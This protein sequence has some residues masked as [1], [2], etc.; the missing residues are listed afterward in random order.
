MG[1]AGNAS[2]TRARLADGPGIVLLLLNV[3]GRDIVPDEVR[4]RAW[5]QMRKC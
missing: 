1:G 3:L 2:V 5:R 4:L